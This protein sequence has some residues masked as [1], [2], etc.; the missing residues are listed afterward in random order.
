MSVKEGRRLIEMEVNFDESST[1]SARPGAGCRRGVMQ[2]FEAPTRAVPAAQN[3]RSGAKH[4]RREARGWV[5]WPG[6]RRALQRE[7]AACK[8]RLRQSC[9]HGRP[10]GLESL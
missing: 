4:W 3:Q 8:P 5:S 2:T 7:T 1:V 10:L 9:I 6:A